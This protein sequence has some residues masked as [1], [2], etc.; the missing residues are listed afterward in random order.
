MAA[1]SGMLGWP[2]A[3]IGQHH[4]IARGVSLLVGCTSIMLGLMWGYPIVGRLF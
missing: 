2:I 3:R 4:A 1:L